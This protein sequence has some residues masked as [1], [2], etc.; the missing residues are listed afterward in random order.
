MG[1]PARAFA[2]F[3]ELQSAQRSDRDVAARMAALSAPDAGDP[4][5]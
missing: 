5:A 2:A 3:M 1:E 4:H